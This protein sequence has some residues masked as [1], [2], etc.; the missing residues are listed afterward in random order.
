MS[1]GRTNDALIIRM[2]GSFEKLG[3]RDEIYPWEG[4]LPY[5]LQRLIAEYGVVEM[6]SPGRP[7]SDIIASLRNSSEL[8]TLVV[9]CVFDDPW[10]AADYV[11]CKERMKAVI[12]GSR[13][14]ARAVRA[15]RIIFAVSRGEKSL[16]D[17]L[18]S[19]AGSW[20]PPS[21][22]VLVGSRYPQ[23]NQRELELVM[24]NY[25]KRENIDLGSFL[26]LGPATLAAV[27]DAVKMKMPILDRY[28][29][30]G[31]SAVKKPQVVKVR[32][33]AR[34]GEVF[35]QCGGF[36]SHPRRIAVGSPLLGRMVTDLDEPIMKTTY[37][38]FALLEGQIPAD[39]YSSCI[40]CGECRNVCPVGLDPE[41]LFKRTRVNGFSR[42]EIMAGRAAECHGCGCCEAVCPSRL[43]LSSAITASAI[44][45]N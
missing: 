36:Y 42:E 8:V 20:E 39:P 7:V 38:V 31:G 12:E 21:S 9:R 44:R 14:L 18:L 13:I 1:D 28:V 22:M 23:R 2:E 26:V 25:G 37:A 32:L 16:G 17:E 33:G 15:G 40:S 43:P 41:E 11:L 29:A 30:V 34:I 5:D 4:L 3:K 6:E 45:E 27:H 19:H 35:E 10:L 24:R